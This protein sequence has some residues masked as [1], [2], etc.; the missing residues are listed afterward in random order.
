MALPTSISSIA[1][2]KQDDVDTITG[3]DAGTTTNVGD[4]AAHHNALANAVNGLESEFLDRSWKASVVASTTGTLL[5]TYA[6]GTAG[7]GATL[8]ASPS[9]ALP[10]FDGITLSVGNRVLVKDQTT[11]AQNGIY[12][13]TTATSPWV[14]TRALDS[15]TA[16]KLADCRVLIDQGNS[17]GIIT[18]N[19]DTE[20]SQVASAPLTIGTSA[21]Q[22]RRTSPPYQPGSM[23][24]PWLPGAATAQVLGINGI[25]QHTT[26]SMTIGASAQHVLNGGIVVQAG[27]TV[28]SVNFIYSVALATITTFWVSLVKMSDLSVLAT[29]AN[30]TTAWAAPNQT[31]TV[32]LSSPLTFNYDTPVYVGIAGQATTGMVVASM[33]TFSTGVGSR[34]PILTGT[35]TAPTATPPTN[36][37]TMAAI[38][39][40]T[41]M[42]LVWLT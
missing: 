42:P 10:T 16:S 38:T 28:T 26:G 40:G 20:W 33:T 11:P 8:T 6:N 30:S 9:A 37:T 21:I 32:A 19:A 15:D 22:W 4:H 35:T 24:N 39:A 31:K 27:R 18:G 7:V 13:V 14:L 2:N 5:A 25:P 3:V 41:I 29:S 17:A 12:T 23:R 1:A 36:G 34:V